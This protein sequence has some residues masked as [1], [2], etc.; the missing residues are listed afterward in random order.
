MNYEQGNESQ[1]KLNERINKIIGDLVIQNNVAQVQIEELQ[2]E[3]TKLRVKLGEV[4]QLE[5]MK[6]A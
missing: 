1:R 5:Q 6:N 3:L 2:E 4:N